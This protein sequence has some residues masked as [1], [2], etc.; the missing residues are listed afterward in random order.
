MKRRYCRMEL[1]HFDSSVRR[2]L[3]LWITASFFQEPRLRKLCADDG[4][5]RSSLSQTE[6]AIK[7]QCLNVA[8]DAAITWMDHASLHGVCL[9]LDDN[10][11]PIKLYPRLIAY[12]G[13]QPEIVSIVS[14]TCY[15]CTSARANFAQDSAEC[16]ASKKLTVKLLRRMRNCALLERRKADICAMGMRQPEVNFRLW[17]MRHHPFVDAA[18]RKSTR[19]NSSH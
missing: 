15:M 9:Q 17:S 18:D 16:C 19:L 11:P 8:L 5:K 14:K 7:L 10:R 1:A 12:D 6:R 2:E 13:D 4:K 3:H